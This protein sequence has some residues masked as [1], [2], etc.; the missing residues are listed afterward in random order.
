MDINHNLV[1]DLKNMGLWDEVKDQIVE[2][3]GDIAAISQIPAYLKQIYKTSFTTSPYAFVEIAARAQKWVDQALSRNIYLESRDMEEMGNLYMAAWKRG[4]KTTYYLHMK[5]RHT[6]EQSTTNVNKGTQIGKK[7]FAGVIAM[8]A[9]TP[10]LSPIQQSP[11]TVAEVVPLTPQAA[12]AVEVVMPEASRGFAPVAAQ[13][14][15]PIVAPQ[16]QTLPVQAPVQNI[17]AAM[18]MTPTPA[19]AGARMGFATVATSM[20]VIAPAVAT[21][22]SPEPTIVSEASESV[23]VKKK[24]FV[25]PVDPAERAQCDS[26]Q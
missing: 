5:P 10:I 25:C 6:A 15:L 18:P 14:A 11:V 13:G 21:A 2:L 22:P 8:P 20:S 19:H 4:L 24:A 3:Q 17:Q 16:Q 23:V 12:P 26:C 7:G 9:E 1:K